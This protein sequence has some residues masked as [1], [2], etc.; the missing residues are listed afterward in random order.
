MICDSSKLKYLDVL[1]KK[2]KAEN[3][4]VLIFC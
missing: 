2:L 1:L 3:H 4:R